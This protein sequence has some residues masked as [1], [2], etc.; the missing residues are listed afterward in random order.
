MRMTDMFPRF[1]R[2][3]LKVKDVTVTAADVALDLA[4]FVAAPRLSTGLLIPELRG[5]LDVPGGLRGPRGRGF[6]SPD[7]Q[8]VRECVG[9]SLIVRHTTALWYGIMLRMELEALHRE[10]EKISR[11][12]LIHSSPLLTMY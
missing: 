4:V 8:C 12:S 7:T 10:P 6:T 9:K 11:P 1:T 5:R 2:W 3:W